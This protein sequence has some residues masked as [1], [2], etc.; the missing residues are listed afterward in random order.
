MGF[1]Q[2]TRSCVTFAAAA[3][4]AA[5]M[6]GCERTGSK[7]PAKAGVV[8]NAATQ[9][10]PGQAPPIPE[11]GPLAQPKS[12]QQVGV[13]VEATRA[14]TPVDNPQ[15]PEKIALGMQLFF[16]G[17]LSADGTV[18]CSTCH[19][20]AH[21]F[22]DGRPTS[23]GHRLFRHDMVRKNGDAAAEVLAFIQSRSRKLKPDETLLV[24][25]GKPVGVF[26]THAGAPRDRRLEPRLRRA[27]RTRT[28]RHVPVV[29]VP[30][31]EAV[32]PRREPES[33]D[34]MVPV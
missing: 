28:D 21:A 29:R 11:A 1:T 34:S 14:L 23:I 12:L 31:V 13:P 16:D 25:S 30:G 22:T 3:A 2:K 6:L 19:D 9:L 5:L 18:A 27:D 10:Q 15:T 4:I 33:R 20:P 7:L 17:R 32:L 26:R 8:P 24:Q